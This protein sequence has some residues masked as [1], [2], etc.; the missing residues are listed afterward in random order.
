MPSSIFMD[1]NVKNAAREQKINKKSFPPIVRTYR[2]VRLFVAPKAR[3]S[4]ASA[5]SSALLNEL[6]IRGIRTG[7]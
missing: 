1:K 4:M 5:T 3:D 7:I 2:D 6:I